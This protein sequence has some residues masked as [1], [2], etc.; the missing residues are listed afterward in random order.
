MNPYIILAIVAALIVCVGLLV[1]A[2]AQRPNASP[3]MHLVQQVLRDL[4]DT[5]APASGF[6]KRCWLWLGPRISHRPLL[7]LIAGDVA[8]G[9]GG[10]SLLEFFTQHPRV[11]FVAVPAIL[12]MHVL[13]PFTPRDAPD[14]IPP[15]NPNGPSPAMQGA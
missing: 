10:M 4:R 2:N 8:L 5:V 3:F 9:S 7:A 6:I 14:R 13:A 15:P 12:V 1:V 11:A